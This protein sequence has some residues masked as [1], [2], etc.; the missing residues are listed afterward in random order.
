M[1]V[2]VQELR[3]HL[4][5]HAYVG[6][7][8]MRVEVIVGLVHQVVE[9]HLRHL[10]LARLLVSCHLLELL[11]LLHQQLVVDADVLLVYCLASLVQGSQLILVDR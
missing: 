5:V 9:E 11:L 4:G 6:V 1:R 7:V 10:A 3:R 2:L 8:L